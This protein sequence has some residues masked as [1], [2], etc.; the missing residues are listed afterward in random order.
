M[1]G[2]RGPFPSSSV[3][4]GSTGC[5][6][7]KI[8]AWVRMTTPVKG[9]DPLRQEV[10]PPSSASTGWAMGFWEPSNLGVTSES[11]SKHRR[12]LNALLCVHWRTTSC[13]LNGPKSFNVMIFKTKQDCPG[14]FC[15]KADSSQ[16]ESILEVGNNSSRS[17]CFHIQTSRS[18]A[19]TP[20][21]YVIGFSHSRPHYSPAPSPQVTVPD[22]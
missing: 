15:P 5:L 8:N 16:D 1:R 10:P 18:R 9:T 3:L 4:C 6:G 2:A 19:H 13:H 22:N 12:E 17:T 14:E 20:A 7:S 11:D 21:I